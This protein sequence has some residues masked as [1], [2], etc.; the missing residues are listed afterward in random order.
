MDFQRWSSTPAREPQDGPNVPLGLS[1][2][3]TITYLLYLSCVHG[4]NNF[5]VACIWLRL[6]EVTVKIKAVFELF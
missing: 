3:S 2:M 5:C 4:A 1:L 6:S